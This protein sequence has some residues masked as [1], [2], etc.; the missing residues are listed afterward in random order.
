MSSCRIVLVEPSGQVLFEGKSVLSEP[1][2]QEEAIEPCPPTK[3][4]HVSGFF[5]THEREAT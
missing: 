2:P 1:P 5:R 3:R 4:S